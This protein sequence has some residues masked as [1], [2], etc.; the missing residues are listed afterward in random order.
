MIQ[1]HVIHSKSQKE[2]LVCNQLDLRMIDTFF[3][4]IRVQPVNP[5]ARKIKPYFPGYIFARFD[6]QQT[7]ISDL[8]WIPGA[9]GIVSFGGEPACIPDHFITTLQQHLDKINSSGYKVI[10]SLNM[11]DTVAIKEGPF[12]G[13]QA[14]FDSRLQGTDRVRVLLQMMQDQQIRV[15]IPV[16]QITWKNSAQIQA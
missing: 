13:Y 7:S 11:G 10:D 16:N 5:R 4:C 14:I 6:L 2:E 9:I 8:Q 12:A 3:P 15:E 1:W